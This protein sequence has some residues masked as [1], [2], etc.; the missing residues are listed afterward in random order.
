MYVFALNFRTNEEF[1]YLINP[2]GGSLTVVSRGG[3]GGS[4]GTGGDGGAGGDGRDGRIWTEKHKEKRIVQQPVTRKVIKKEKRSVINAAGQA[5]EVEVNVETSVT[6]ME[7]SE[8]EVEVVE[9]K[10]GPGENG[11][12]GGFGGNG[13]FGGYGGFGGNIE[14][15]F[16]KDAMPLKN[17]IVARSAGGNGGFHGSGGHGGPGGRGGQGNPDGDTGISGGAGFGGSGTAENG[18]QGRITSAETG[19]FCFSVPKK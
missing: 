4:G 6:V 7:N 5:E 19:E 16:T 11:Y 1:R 18:S 8:V 3:D 14:L 12:P 13:G 10:Q 15:Y 17:L 2:E 9:Q